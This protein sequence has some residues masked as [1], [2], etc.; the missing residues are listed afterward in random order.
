MRK[1][2]VFV[3]LGIALVAVL[4][5]AA[6]VGA[7][8]LAPKVKAG[9]SGDGNMMMINDGGGGAPKTFN[10]DFIPAKELPQTP[11]D[12]S[13]IFVRRQDSSVFIGTG[14]VRMEVKKAPGGSVQAS[15]NHTGPEVEVVTTRDTKI[16]QDVTL[17]QYQGDPPQDVRFQQVLEPGSLDGI[18]ENSQVTVWG[19]KSGNRLT[20]EYLIYSQPA[21][22]TRP[23]GNQPTQ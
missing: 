23:G 2:I 7:Q 17:Q 14:D 15:S 12:E 6:F 21:F 11:S 22:M 19:Q 10:L 8:M 5:G 1:P 9:S 16:F 20:A 18:G 3:I 13:G 4:A